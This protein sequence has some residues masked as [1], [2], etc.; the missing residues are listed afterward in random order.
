[1]ER[2]FNL[3]NQKTVKLGGC[4]NS[5]TLRQ[6]AKIPDLY[7][8]SDLNMQVSIRVIIIQYERLNK[9]LLNRKMWMKLL[10]RKVWRGPI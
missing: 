7:K 8:T 6:L 4:Q 2:Y 10:N 5:A 9:K 1:M 3:N